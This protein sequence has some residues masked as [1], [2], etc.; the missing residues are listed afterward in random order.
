MWTWEQSSCNEI[1]IRDGD[2]TVMA[3]ICDNAADEITDE[4]RRRANLIVDAVNSWM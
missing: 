2:G 4:H 1:T 3:T